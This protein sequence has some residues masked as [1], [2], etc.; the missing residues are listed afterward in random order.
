MK[1]IVFCALVAS[2]FLT[3]C[4]TTS[5][6]GSGINQKADKVVRN[7]NQLLDYQGSTFGSEIPEW[8]VQISDG[9]Y[10]EQVLKGV[11]PGLEKKKVFVTVGRG[12]N[13]EFVRNWTDLVEI[14]VQIGDT[15]E[16][17][18]GKSVKASMKGTE[19]DVQRKIDMY[20]EAISAVEV[21]GLEKIASYWVK[22]LVVTPSLEKKGKET[23]EIVY[24]YYSVWAMDK[25]TYEA[26]LDAAL[27]GIPD[28]TSEGE[29]LKR[30]LR[31]DLLRIMASSTADVEND[32]YASE[33]GYS[34]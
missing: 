9:Q 6:K 22:K 28:N 33:F 27:Q 8:V 1:K 17:I 34:Y 12:K 25:K 32:I 18:V 29:A 31:E 20:K 14:E 11:M 19:E 2:L 24:E 4:A 13:L 30:A 26:Q 10:S 3:G 7:K 5:V 16:R 15:F 23:Q 21:N